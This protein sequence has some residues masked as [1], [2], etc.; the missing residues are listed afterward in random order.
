MGILQSTSTQNDYVVSFWL[1]VFVYFGLSLLQERRWIYS[2]SAAAS[3]GLAWLVKGTGYIYAAPFLVWIIVGG[4]K[5]HGRR[6]WAHLAGILLIAVLIN[7]SYYARN[8][9]LSGSIVPP[10]ESTR[11]ISSKLDL[12]VL[13]ANFVLNLGLQTATVW[14]KPNQFIEQTVGQVLHWAGIEQ[15]D[16]RVYLDG[17]SFDLPSPS[18]RRH[19]D[20][21]GNPVQTLLIIFCL[22]ASLFCGQKISRDSRYYSLAMLGTIF[23]FIIVIKWSAFHGR[24]HLPVFILFAPFIAAVLSGCFRSSVCIVLAAVLMLGSM[25]WVVDNK[26][27][28]LIGKRNV[29]VSPRMDQYFFN[30]ESQSSYVYPLVVA[31]QVNCKQIGEVLGGEA[32]EFPLMVISKWQHRKD[33]RFEHILVN[34]TS[35]KLSYP[36]GDFDPCMIIENGADNPDV[37]NWQGHA[38]KKFDQRGPIASYM[39]IS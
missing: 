5:A 28:P 39:R 36:L 1:V 14:D 11:A 29:L 13:T 17:T 8:Y 4:F 26:T 2:M 31:E 24:Y 22:L 21:A 9:S 37:L 18:Y 12:K 34:N 32:W 16:K 25:P 33:L 35:S 19:E 15:G 6:F 10:S 30:N 20:Y 3:L 38:F 27:R 23:L 7:S